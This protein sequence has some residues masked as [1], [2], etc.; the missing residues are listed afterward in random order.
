MTNH[1]TFIEN[2]DRSLTF[3]FQSFVYQFLIERVSINCFQKSKTKMMM[4]LKSGVDNLLCYILINH[5]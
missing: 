1:I 2:V 4:N 5:K 3:T